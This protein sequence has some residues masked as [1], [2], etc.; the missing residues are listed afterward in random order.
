MKVAYNFLSS[1]GLKKQKQ[2]LGAKKGFM[3][4]YIGGL[5][6]RRGWF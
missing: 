5:T 1:W 2:I 6:T 4:S 3:G